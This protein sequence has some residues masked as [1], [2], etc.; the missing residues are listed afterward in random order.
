VNALT[1]AYEQAR[2][3]PAGA[4]PADAEAA[5]AALGRLQAKP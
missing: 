4:A 1:A 3:N 5:E 2:Y